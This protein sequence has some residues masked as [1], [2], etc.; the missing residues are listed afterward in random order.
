MK[1][2]AYFLSLFVIFVLTHH[3]MI[4]IHEWVHGFVAWVAE[5]KSS[6]FDIYYGTQWFTLWD[7]NEAVDY[8]KIFS[9]GKNGVVAWTAISPTLLQMIL[10]PIGLK[11]LSLSKVQKNGWLFVFFYFFNLNL[12]GETY[13]YIPIRT[14]S[15]REDIFNFVQATHISPVLIAILGALY[16]LWGVYQLLSKQIPRAYSSLKITTKAGRYTFKLFTFAVIFF[17][18]GAA[19]LIKPDL[20]PHLLGLV[21]W[22]IFFLSI[23]ILGT[24]MMK[25]IKAKRKKKN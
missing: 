2:L 1:R 17:Y 12:L 6:P 18:Y 3:L 25:K 15:G 4:Y 7:I 13:A 10:F 20:I 22:A 11:I 8:P 19:G 21:S 16:V 23:G 14:F 5:Y 24:Q 9:D